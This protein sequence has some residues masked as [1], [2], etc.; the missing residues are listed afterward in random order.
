MRLSH[1]YYDN[2]ANF[3]LLPAG[4]TVPI[5]DD[6][7][8]F[9]PGGGIVTF[10]NG[11]IGNPGAISRDSELDLVSSY[12]G[13]QQHNWRFGIGARYQTVKATETKN[14]GPGVIDGTVPV[15]DGTLTDVS[16]TDNVYLPD[17]S[18]RVNYLSVQDEWQFAPDWQLIA[19]VRYD[20]YSDFGNTTNPRVALVW[21][22]NDQLTTKFLYG[23]A[24]KVPSFL[25]LFSRNNPSI[26]GNA[27][28]DPETIDTFEISFNYR[29]HPNL[30]T[31]LNL[32]KYKAEDLIEFTP[33]AENLRDQNGQGFEWEIDW[34]PSNQFR[35]QA[36]FA[37]QQS[38]DADTKAT[39]ADAPGNQLTINSYWQFQPEWFLNTTIN[40][41]ADRQRAANDSRSDIKD[42]TQVDFSLQRKNIYPQLDI[43]LSV[44]NALDKDIREPST[45]NA[46]GQA[47][48]PGDI[49]MEGRSVWLEMNYHLE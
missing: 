27:D 14:F 15:V 20:K 47:S 25:E 46:I 4:A 28:L 42:Y 3:T 19:G 5:G 6:G 1:A 23:S 11:L 9:T 36:N 48:I 35:L 10:P 30:Q 22:T 16:N 17:S 38:E 40:R 44:R 43:S 2:Q 29:P 39:I 33:V 12:N 31:S 24:F 13:W 41:V 49:P 7:N 34:R 45:V 18:R 8:L 37:L 26:I 32:F 21:E